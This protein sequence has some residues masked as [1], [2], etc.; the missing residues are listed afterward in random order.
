[1][2]GRV[3]EDVHGVYIGEPSDGENAIRVGYP[4][5]TAW[6]WVFY[7]NDVRWQ[8]YPPGLGW[9]LPSRFVTWVEDATVLPNDVR[10]HLRI[11]DGEPNCDLVELLAQKTYRSSA[12]P[13][14][15][16]VQ[17]V[18]ITSKGLRQVPVANLIRTS[19]LAALARRPVGDDGSVLHAQ[20]DDWAALYARPDVPERRRGKRLGDE[21]F[22]AVSAVYRNALSAGLPPVQEVA[23][24]FHVSG[25]TAGRWVV[26]ARRRGFLGPAQPGRAGETPLEE[27]ET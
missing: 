22:Q 12:T 9:W 18:P 25:S 5:G 16:Y 7:D 14:M 27:D 13:N 23:R 2:E 4:I 19:I 3:A 10:L 8:E 20:L 15:K 11:H 24:R 26:E 17:A 21:H 6:Y 1:M